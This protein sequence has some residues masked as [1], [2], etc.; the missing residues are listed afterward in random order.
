MYDEGTWED[1]FEKYNECI[2]EWSHPTY[3]FMLRAD[4][5]TKL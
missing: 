1:D 3:A 5:S 4:L 2:I